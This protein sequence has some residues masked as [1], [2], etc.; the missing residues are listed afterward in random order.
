MNR[1]T[2]FNKTEI[3]KRGRNG[4][5]IVAQLLME[6]GWHV[7]PS[8]DFT[9]DDANKAPRLKGKKSYYAIPDLDISKDGE[10]L[11]IEVKTKEK[12]VWYRKGNRFEHGMNLRLW[13]GYK[14]VQEIGGTPIWIYIYEEESG[15]IIKQLLDRLAIGA[16]E[17]RGYVMGPGGMIFFERDSFQEYKNIKQVRNE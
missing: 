2:P 16:R 11:W 8:Y 6:D 10:R 4:E 3:Y 14:H 7:I 1:V 5:E 9:G 12:P 13:N 15:W 17:Y